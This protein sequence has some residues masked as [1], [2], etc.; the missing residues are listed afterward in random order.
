MSDKSATIFERRHRLEKARGEFQQAAMRDYNKDLF[1]P[2]MKALR[3]ECAAKGHCPGSKWH[4]N[5]I[6]WRWRYCNQC[7]DRL[8]ITGPDE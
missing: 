5:G 1:Y 2:A 8:D 4:D 7:A 6:G 3:E